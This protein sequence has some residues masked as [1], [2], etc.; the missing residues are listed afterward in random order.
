M[1][2]YL[3]NRGRGGNIGDAIISTV[4]ENSLHNLGFEVILNDS[5]PIRRYG[6]LPAGL[7]HLNS[8]I[9]DIRKVK[10]SDL[11]VIGG[12]NLIMDV[13][14]VK[15]NW[16]LHHFW[17]SLLS[18]FFHKK[19]YYCCVGAAPLQT[20]V[21]RF[22]YRRALC[23]ARKISA[24]DSFSAQYIRELIGREDVWEMFDPALLISSLY[25]I[26]KNKRR[27]KKRSIGI[28][29][30]QLY[31]FISPDPV[32]QQR[33]VKL[34]TRLIDTFIH[35][36]HEVFLFLNDSGYDAAVFREIKQNISSSTS[37]FHAI[38][39]FSDY[40]EYLPFIASLDFLV[41]SRL[42]S[43]II[44]VSYSIP[45]IGYGWQ[46][47]MKYF[48]QD[49]NL[50]GYINIIDNLVNEEALERT[51]SYTIE[52]YNTTLFKIPKIQLKTL[53]MEE[54]LDLTGQ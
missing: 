39:T 48:Y 54:F 44:A 14:G 17:L 27:S 13:S 45:T 32:I 22:L 47:K 36:G 6:P 30:V 53:R 10:E 16:A 28:C 20:S 21:A 26:A 46:P 31:P 33:Y 40:A 23:N 37:G 15:A 8:F 41:T 35:N 19:Y 42:H 1:K 18:R 50:D 51:F 12:G 3:Y 52:L 49:N 5:Y 11:V 38:E 2:V 4:L 24:R 9:G 7:I 25:P 29:P 34:H 43:A